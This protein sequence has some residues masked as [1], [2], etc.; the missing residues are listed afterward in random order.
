MNITP[1]NIRLFRWIAFYIFLA[2]GNIL[3]AQ[4]NRHWA[5]LFNEEASLVAGSVVG[6][7]AAS[8]SIFYNPASI[9]EF[10]DNSLTVNASLFTLKYYKAT[11]ALGNDMDLSDYEFEI[12]PRFVA[13]IIES[14][15]YPK[16]KLEIAILTKNN[17][18]FRFEDFIEQKADVNSALSGAEIHIT[19]FINRQRYNET[20]AGIGRSHEINESFSL[21]WSLFGVYKFMEYMNRQNIKIIPQSDTVFVNGNPVPAYISEYAEN[22]RFRVNNYRALLKIGGLWTYDTWSFGWNITTPS[23]LVFSGATQG[24]IEV[25][26]TNVKTDADLPPSSSAYIEHQDDMRSDFKDPGSVA[27][28]ATYKG[29]DPNSVFSVSAEYFFGLESYKILEGE[30]GRGI[31]SNNANGIVL[32]D[33]PLT[34]IHGAKPVLNAAIGYKWYV[35][36]NLK[37]LTGFRTD[38]NYMKNHELENF[39]SYNTIKQLNFDVYHLTAGTRL[40]IKNHYVFAGLQY[41]FGQEEGQSQFINVTEIDEFNSIEGKPFQ[42]VRQNN[43]DILF[44]SLSLFFGVNFNFVKSTP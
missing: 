36:E 23:I 29:S 33:E 41:S 7:G 10:T 1:I 21:G 26:S 16:R 14:K 32:T 34:Y 39:E 37:L 22:E 44:R 5:Q 12:Y 35:S 2:F 4:L 20:W 11:N 17:V 30:S 6:G 15:K 13:F 28:G 24:T 8:S 40:T 3:H 31:S 9:S 19:D 42:G 25:S 18:N 43:V 38:F 27:V